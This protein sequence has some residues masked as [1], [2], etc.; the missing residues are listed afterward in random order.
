[1]PDC[2]LRVA[3]STR[4]VKKF[5]A[6]S[7]LEPADVYFR[8]EPGIVKSRGPIK[9]SGFN[10]SLSGFHGTSI[11]KQA[12]QAIKFIEAHRDDFTALASYK[13][14]HAT[15]DF[16]LYDLTTEKRPWPCYRLPKRLVELAGAY[17][18]ETDRRN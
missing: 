6:E 1:M 15:L 18:G 14:R 12:R 8:G 9:I 16:G 3:G 17:S 4:K 5:L 7:S 11:A 10:V 2:V 13:F